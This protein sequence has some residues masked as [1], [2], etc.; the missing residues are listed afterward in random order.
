MKRFTSISTF[1]LLA[2]ALAFIGLA[3]APAEAQISTLALGDGAS[4]AGL[5]FSGLIVNRSNLTELFTGFKTAFN[6]GLGQAEPQSALVRT[7]VP[8]GT[9]EEKYAWLGK[10]P[11]FRKW[12][13]DRVIQNLQQHDYAIKNESYEMTVAVGRDEIED[14]Q[15]GVYA[16]VFTEMGRNTAAHPEEIIWPMLN[17]GFAATRGLAYD[18][19]FFFDTDH[20]VLDANGNPVSVA[21]TDGGAG[22]PWFLADLSRSLRPII[23][24]TRRAYDLVRLDNPTDENVFMRKEYLY[25]VDARVNAGYGLWQTNWG[26][27]QALDKANYKIARQELLGMKGD[28]GRPL[29]IRPTHLIVPPSL[30]FAGMEILNSERDAAGATNVYRGTAKLLVVPW[31]A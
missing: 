16:P 6:N 14:D 17:D 27:K 30:E 1:A 7:E 10:I 24:Q 20:P 8:S 11:G 26:S 2:G 23:W 21:N 5:A 31:L 4:I 19:Q 3:T 13:G 18:G 25:G 29:G 15:F 12:A 9:S 22:T 28:Y